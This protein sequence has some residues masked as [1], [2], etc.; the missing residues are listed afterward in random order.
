MTTPLATRLSA[1]RALRAALAL[2]FL[3]GASGIASG[4]EPNSKSS[5]D[6]EASPTRVRLE[7]WA[8]LGAPVS[9]KA[10]LGR[11]SQVRGWRFDR[12]ARHPSRPSWG[13]GAELDVEVFDWASVG[14]SGWEIVQPSGR[15]RIHYEGIEL[16]GHAFAGETR[17]TTR[18]ELR[19]SEVSL[20]YVWRNDERVRLWFGIGVAWLS[21]RLALRGDRV[22][23]TTRISEV[24]APSLTYAL[25]AKL[26]AGFEVFLLSGIAF[27]PQRFPSLTT[28]FRVGFGYRLVPGV[29]LRLGVGLRNAFL[30]E[31]R[32]QLSKR[33]RPGHDWRRIRWTSLGAELGVAFSL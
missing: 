16:D 23:A 7:L 10:K 33:V 19:Y 15:R 17:L 29:S 21:T 4:T 32:E 6:P 27:A 31:A 25:E 28:R 22:R 8:R 1:P 9:G 3:L 2:W 13:Y 20:R 5:S 11:D 26:G 30:G 24:F 14:V 18:I 12:D